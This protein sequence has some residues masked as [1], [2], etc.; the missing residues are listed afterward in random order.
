MSVF[1]RRTGPLVLIVEDDPWIRNISGELLKDEGFAVASAGDGQAG[2]AAAERLRPTVIVLD[3]GLPRLSGGEFL[4]NLRGSQSLA[5]TP[6]I[7]VTGQAGAVS[8]AVTAMANDVLRKPF[9]L[10]ELIEKVRQ[11][12]EQADTASTVSVGGAPQCLG[13]HPGVSQ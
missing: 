2:F 6:V 7:L 12:A 9:D 10:T 13:S 5:N 8:E 1:D 11:A 4:A 3:L